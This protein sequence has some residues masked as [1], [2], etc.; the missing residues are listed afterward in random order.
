[1]SYRCTN[2]AVSQIVYSLLDDG[3]NAISDPVCNAHCDELAP[4]ETVAILDVFGDH[5][6][7]AIVDKD[8]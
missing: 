3:R 2:V 1:M 7:A 8:M 4:A 5:Q 6:C